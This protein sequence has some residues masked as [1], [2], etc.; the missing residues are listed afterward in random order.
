MTS[1]L[2]GVKCAGTA[3]ASAS[4]IARA[5]LG[6]DVLTSFAAATAV[7]HE[8]PNLAVKAVASK[9]KRLRNAAQKL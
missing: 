7:A 6:L 3:N 4:T 1:S 2:H 5:H 8:V 9:L